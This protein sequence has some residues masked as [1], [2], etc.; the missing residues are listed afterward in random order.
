MNTENFETYDNKKLFEITGIKSKQYLKINELKNIGMI[1]LRP[2][3]LVVVNNITDI[4]NL[5]PTF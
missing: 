2:I 3:Q 5:S 1:T 4:A